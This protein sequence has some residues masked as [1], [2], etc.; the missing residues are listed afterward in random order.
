MSAGNN[1]PWKWWHID[2]AAAALCVL[3]TVALY[4]LMVQPLAHRN[5]AY[6]GQQRELDQARQEESVLARRLTGQRLDLAGVDAALRDTPLQ[7][8]DSG[9]MNKR[10]SDLTELAH[11]CRLKI[12]QIQPGKARRGGRYDVVPIRLV[13]QGS[14][15]NAAAFL[16]KMHQRFKDTGVASL[17][18]SADPTT[19]STPAAF[20]FEL[21][22][23]T[24]PAE[25]L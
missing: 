23:Y 13:G 9:I 22:W 18:L 17:E 11:A 8:A 19:S 16:N 3:V 1:A 6:A 12:D 14:Y 5:A 10:L 25:D 21:I 15:P 4:L 2:A 7:L 20:T 24:A